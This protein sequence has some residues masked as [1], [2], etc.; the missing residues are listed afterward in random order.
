MTR[1]DLLTFDGITQPVSEWALDY[2]IP[3]ELMIERINA[4][5]SI[6]RAIT[7][8]ME[9]A[10]GQ[11]LPLPRAR[12]YTHGGNTLT[13]R[14]WAERTGIPKATLAQRLA[15]GSS[16]ADAI[17]KD[18]HPKKNV[19]YTHNGE[20]MTLGGWSRRS[21]IKYDTLL[22]RVTKLGMSVGEAM[23]MPKHSKPGSASRECKPDYPPDITITIAGIQ[24]TI[25]APRGVGLNF[26]E[27]SGTGGGRHAQESAEIE[28]SPKEVSQ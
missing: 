15:R 28:F 10:P 16:L 1:D 2:G 24:I 21:G 18:K 12:L 17:D 26:R 20:T 11:K 14:E 8:P 19:T 25:T 22:Y 5:Q 7:T 23:T 3:A 27:A 4:G 13:L 9:A 6:D